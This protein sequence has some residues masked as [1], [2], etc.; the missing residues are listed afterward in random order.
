MELGLK[1]DF[2]AKVYKERP[3][4]F[5]RKLFFKSSLLSTSD[6]GTDSLL[7]ILLFI[8]LI[9]FSWIV[10]L[11]NWGVSKSIIIFWLSKILI[12][13][14]FMELFVISCAIPWFKVELF[15]DCPMILISVFIL[16]IFLP[17]L[18]ILSLSIFIALFL[19]NV[20]SFNI[21]RELPFYF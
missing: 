14:L 20:F 4:S 21:N 5:L 10:L 12:L 13:L 2:E 7:R 19:L 16:L 1:F 17:K 3:D 8:S 11:G 18:Q 6:E 15:K 9:I